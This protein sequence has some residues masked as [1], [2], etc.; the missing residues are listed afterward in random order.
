MSLTNTMP[1]SISSTAMRFAAR[2]VAREDAAAQAERRCRWRRRSRASSS[3]TGMIAA[4][5]P[6]ISSS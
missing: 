4:T 5:G 6:N 1:P 2:E 3:A